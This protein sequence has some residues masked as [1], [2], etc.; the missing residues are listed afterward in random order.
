MSRRTRNRVKAPEAPP[1]PPPPAS[2]Q[3]A[4]EAAYLVLARGGRLERPEWRFLM[5]FCPGDAYF[6]P[7][8]MR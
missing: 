7:I 6:M 5:L 1:K 3:K 2:W 8:R 4:L